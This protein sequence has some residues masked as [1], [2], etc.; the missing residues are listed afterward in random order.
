MSIWALVPTVLLLAAMVASLVR[1]VRR[2]RSSVEL[3]DRLGVPPR[4][5][6]GIGV[7]EGFAAA[8]LVTGVFQ[9]AVGTAAAVGVA[10]LMLGAIMARLRVGLTGRWL[11]APTILLAAAIVAGFGFGAS[12]ASPHGHDGADEIKPESATASTDDGRTNGHELRQ[13][14]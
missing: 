6:S 1:K 7:L 2:A 13:S 12:A 3:R 10:L 5:W 11:L 4:L 8:G 9:A 14:Y